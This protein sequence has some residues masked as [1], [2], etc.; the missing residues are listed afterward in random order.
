[1]ISR[2]KGRAWLA[3]GDVALV[4]GVWVLAMAFMSWT[5]VNQFRTATDCGALSLSSACYQI[6]SARVT[7]DN[8]NGHSKG[9]YSDDLTIDLGSGSRTLTLWKD[10]LDSLTGAT[11][12]AKL[13]EGD[14]TDVMVSGRDLE[15]DA[16]PEKALGDTVWFGLGLTA[17]GA[18]AAVLQVQAVRRWRRRRQSPVL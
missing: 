12:R 13:W 11:V 14:I 7:A 18:V 10:G 5:R 16:N 3:A 6:V 9:S 15:T 8:F 2:W 17:A 4:L 1:M